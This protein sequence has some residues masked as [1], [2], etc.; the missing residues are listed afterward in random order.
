MKHFKSDL[1]L[2]K[3]VALFLLHRL[4]RSVLCIDFLNL[5]LSFIVI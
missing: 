2:A 4:S 3:P 1:N 5:Y